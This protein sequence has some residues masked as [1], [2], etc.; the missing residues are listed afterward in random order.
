MSDYVLQNRN[1]V[2]TS[3]PHLNVKF[4]YSLL[5]FKIMNHFHITEADRRI[6]PDY[7]KYENKKK[8]KYWNEVLHAVS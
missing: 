7:K 8:N 1:C 4:R 6:Y 3:F 5:D 2:V